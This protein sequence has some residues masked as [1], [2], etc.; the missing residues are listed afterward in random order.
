MQTV[1][2]KEVERGLRSTRERSMRGLGGGRGS[3]N[4]QRIRQLDDMQKKGKILLAEECSFWITRSRSDFVSRGSPPGQ[5]IPRVPNIRPTSPEL[6]KADHLYQ[7]KITKPLK[8]PEFPESDQAP[9]EGLKP[10]YLC[11][12]RGTKPNHLDISRGTKT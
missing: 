11:I 12:S 1:V 3:G 5:C 9:P 10:N 2:W 6:Y 7:N 8:S 4:L